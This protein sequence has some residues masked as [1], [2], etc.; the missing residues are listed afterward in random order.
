MST[1]AKLPPHID[2]D[3]FV[4]VMS[5]SKFVYLP[6]RTLCDHAAVARRLGVKVARTAEQTRACSNLYWQPG[7]DMIVRDKAL[8]EGGLTDCPGNNLFNVYVPPP[9]PVGGDPEKAQFWLDLGEFLW[10]EDLDDILDF[11]AFKVQHPER[12]INHALVLGSYEQGI[13]K[14][15]FLYPLNAALGRWNYMSIQA[16]LAREWNEKG[17]NAPFLRKVITQIS[18]VHDLGEG[19]FSW[20]DQTKDWCAAPPM[21]LMVANKHV[22][23][24][25]IA[26]VLAIIYTTNHK[27]DGLYLPQSDR[28]HDVKWSQRTRA[29]FEPGGEMANYFGQQDF[30]MGY[31]QSIHY[32]LHEEGHDL[33][34]AAYLRSRDVRAYDPGKTP[35]H[36]AA[37]HEIVQANLDP[38]TGELAEVI[39]SVTDD[40]GQPPV[41][42]TKAMVL[43]EC[44]RG[45]HAELADFLREGKNARRWTKKFEE[46]GYVT[47]ANPDD[48]SG[49]W[50]VG[51]VRQLVY[52]PR[53]LPPAERLKAARALIATGDAAAAAGAEEIEEFA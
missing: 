11:L 24:H 18:E 39:A 1:A 41:A 23:P 7:L 43:S 50:R 29:D 8:I 48:Q 34:V 21:T 25:D 32:L 4:W 47:V 44:G 38:H 3:Q 12:K 22:K 51:G 35:R 16:G 10:G 9:E 13:G 46:A 42:L 14:D 27:A 5:E 30:G 28:R 20:Y 15:T 49:R 45:N 53:E 17:F 6:T 36:T 19:R 37:W 31:W 40:F 52:A 26:N 33:H 2:P